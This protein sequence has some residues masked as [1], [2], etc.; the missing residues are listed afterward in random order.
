M[1]AAEAQAGRGLRDLVRQTQTAGV[2]RRAVLLHMDRLPPA[3]AKPLHLRLARDALAALSLRDHAQSFE[4]ARGRLAIVW[5]GKGQEEIASAMAAL[6]QLLADLP[7]TNA[8][9][10]GHM[11]SIFDLPDQAPWLLDALA[12]PE[13]LAAPSP[14][15]ALGLDAALLSRLEEGLAQADL[16]QFL[17]RRPVMD[18]SAATPSLAWEDRTISVADMA[19]SLCPGRHLAEGTWLFRRLARSIDRRMLALMTGPLELAGSRP[20]SLRVCVSS[21]LSANF[22]AFDA[23]LPAALRGHVVLR[24]EEADILADT[25]SF[26]FARNYAATRGYKLS[27]R[28]GHLRLLDH[29]AAALDYT[30]MTLSA[31]IQADPRLLPDRARLVLSGVDDMAQMAWARA[32]GCSRMKGAVLAT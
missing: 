10:L 19:A 9:P 18:L 5:R 2:A 31:E 17:R 27:A 22:L 6:E 1:N 8:V 30:E 24:L 4:L 29:A 32:Q 21:I 7:Q 12:E 11:V 13:G 28:A 20:F 3:M 15:P 14:D 26:S 16:S 25:M 23:A